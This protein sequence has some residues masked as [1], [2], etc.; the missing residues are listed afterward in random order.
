M[1]AGRVGRLVSILT[2]AEGGWAAS[3]GIPSAA[4]MEV[5]P[6]KKKKMREG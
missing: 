6:E 5:L 4:R 3:P 2:V 1:A